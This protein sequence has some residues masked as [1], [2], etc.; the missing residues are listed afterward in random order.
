MLGSTV[1]LNDLTRSPASPLVAKHR[2]GRRLRRIRS[3]SREGFGLARPGARARGLRADELRLR[4]GEK[5]REGRC[6]RRAPAPSEEEPGTVV[7]PAPPLR[8]LYRRTEESEVSR[9]GRLAARR[10]GASARREGRCRGNNE[11]W[12]RPSGL[13]ADLPRSRRRSKP[14]QGSGPG[15]EQGSGEPRAQG[16]AARESG[17]P[18]A[19]GSPGR[20]ALFAHGADRL[21]ARE[22]AST[23]PW[24]GPRSPRVFRGAGGAEVLARPVFEAVKQWAAPIPDSLSARVLPATQ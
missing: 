19:R 5:S 11:G 6:D 18:A 16:R 8:S 23:S 22:V 2:S 13:L 17:R 15:R 20:R 21:R 1:L 4:A 24:A 10:Q 7:G 3:K 14:H 12:N 9:D